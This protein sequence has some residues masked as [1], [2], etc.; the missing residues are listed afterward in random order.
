VA[1]GLDLIGGDV[2]DFDGSLVLGKPPFF[3]ESAV[4]LSCP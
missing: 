4:M 2:A 3:D 1:K